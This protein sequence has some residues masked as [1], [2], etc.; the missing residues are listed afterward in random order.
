MKKQV[1]ILGINGGFG[2]LFS[3]LL[4]SDEELTITGVDL[5]D[6]IH[7][8]SNCSRY[9]PSDVSV[10]NEELKLVI[11]SSDVIIIC[12]PED[13]AYH[14]LNLYKRFISQT[15][16]LIDT[17]SIKAKVASS[18]IENDF[19]ALSLNPMFGPDLP[20]EGKNIIVIKFK[21]SQTSEWFIALLK[22]WRLQMVYT[23]S[24]EHDK[25]SS[26]IQVATHATLMAF[27]ITLNN[28][29]I[30]VTELL[31]VATP[32]FLNMTALFGRIIS[33]NKNVYWNIQK[34]NGYASAI[35]KTLINNL[36]ALDKSIDE[37]GEEDFNKLIEVKTPEQKEFFQKLSNH[38]L[39]QIKI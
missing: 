36:I 29:D 39:S 13:A 35:R 16:L 32:P 24:D 25:M 20:M 22:T 6:S 2:A 30:P 27:G 19:N 34:E 12:L 7:Q 31:K 8:N 14:F 11:G 4:F 17:L 5:N 1:T 15:A 28:A 9:I 18:Y 33:G 38:F 21:S 37:G 10:F 3:R 26:Y 23:T